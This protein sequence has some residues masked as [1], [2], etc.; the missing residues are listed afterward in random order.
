LVKAA[1]AKRIVTD[2]P[3]VRLIDTQ[4]A[5]SNDAMLGINIEMGFRP[6]VTINAWQGE[7]RTVLERLSG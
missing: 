6:F 2:Y 7:T 5:G 4:N 1:M 3:T